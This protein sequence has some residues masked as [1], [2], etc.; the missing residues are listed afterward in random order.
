[1][2]T[3]TQNSLAEFRQ[4]SADVLRSLSQKERADYSIANLIQ[5]EAEFALRQRKPDV[6]VEKKLL[7]IQHG[8]SMP[9]VESK[10]AVAPRG[11]EHEISQHLEGAFGGTRM[12]GVLVPLCM[13]SGLDSKRHAAGKSSIGQ[14]P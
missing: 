7:A 14:P 10:P 12:G 13:R 3:Y 2:A 6:D 9:A 8:F 1:M 11:L 5:R 4:R